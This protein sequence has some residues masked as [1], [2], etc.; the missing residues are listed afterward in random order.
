MAGSG[1]PP[2]PGRPDAGPSPLEELRR[3]ARARLP[4]LDE[5]RC[6][7]EGAGYEVEAVRAGSSARARLKARFWEEYLSSGRID[8]CDCVDHFFAHLERSLGKDP[9]D[10]G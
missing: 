8:G 3:E 6:R 5:L 1:P 7:K 2:R 9:E 4:G 10:H